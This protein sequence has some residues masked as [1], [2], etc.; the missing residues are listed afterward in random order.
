MMRTKV[1]NK[2]RINVNKSGGRAKKREE[3][4]PQW[5][6]KTSGKYASITTSYSNSL[7]G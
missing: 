7:M 2:E 6:A 1:E 4:V 3:D 5:Y